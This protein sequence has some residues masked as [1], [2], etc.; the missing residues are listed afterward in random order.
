MS[1]KELK[2]AVEWEIE[3]QTPFPVDDA[4]TSW[5]PIEPVDG[6]P[7]SPNMEVLIVVAQKE[8]VAGHVKTVQAAGLAPDVIDVEP[9]AIARALVDLP[10]GSMKDQTIGIVHIGANSTMILVVRKGLL[11]FVRSV[12]TGGKSLSDSVKQNI[13]GEDKA[14]EWAKHA[15]TDLSDAYLDQ[16]GGGP[17]AGYGAEDDDLFAE[18]AGDSVFEESSPDALGDL[19]GQAVDMQGAATQI[20]VPLPGEV[21]LPPETRAAGAGEAG[22]EP[23][24]PQEAEARS[25]VYEAVAPQVVDLA[26]EVRR[27]IDFY[28]RQHRNEEIDRIILSGGSA[29]IPGLPEFI[30]G[31]TGVTTQ[32]ANPFACMSLGD[33]APQEYLAEVGPAMVVAVGLAVRDMVE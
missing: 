21:Q 10:G 27:S 1:G 13:M 16:G 31:E 7:A 33:D 17:A 18:D 32:R 4:V 6:D 20:D 3:R 23:V 29:V 19:G 11:S 9:L 15:L 30:Q 2:E 28:R 24:D 5:V 8:L 14:S 25:I 22:H 12:G 26:T